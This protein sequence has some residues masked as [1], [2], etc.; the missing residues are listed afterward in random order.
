M[1][2]LS[3]RSV[4]P[5]A[6]AALAGAAA[7]PAV[8]AQSPALASLIDAHRVALNTFEEWCSKEETMRD[9]F[10]QAESERPE[11]IVPCLLGGG[12]SLSLGE[13]SVRAHMAQRYG[14]QRDNLKALARVDTDAA[15]TL[16]MKLGD[17]EAEN[18]IV[19]QRA[20]AEEEARKEAFGLTAVL[21][22]YQAANDAEEAALGAVC[23]YVPRSPEE[24]RIKGE[25]LAYW[26]DRTGG[27]GWEDHIPLVLQSI[28]GGANV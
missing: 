23:A 15:E 10:R 27:Y 5:I 3:R 7:L 21:R 12:F 14:Y 26:Y 25:Y 1:A 4:L 20:F 19:I 6:A 28:V 8:A 2:D 22:E 11:D 16:R 9:A 24:G 13:D 18:E 17:T